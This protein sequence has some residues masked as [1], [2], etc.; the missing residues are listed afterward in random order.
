MTRIESKDEMVLSGSPVA[1]VG[2]A[3]PARRRRGLLNAIGAMV[4]AGLAR[5]YFKSVAW[6]SRK[7]FGT[8]EKLGFYLIPRTFYGPIPDTRTLPDE[9][10]KRHS[11]LIGIDMRPQAQLALMGELAERY[12]GEYGILPSQPTDDPRQYYYRNVLYGPADAELAYGLVRKH[13]PRRLIEVGSGNS[14][15]LLAQAVRRNNAET[16]CECRYTVIDPY[17]RPVV[18][19]GIPGVS[20]LIRKPIQHVPLDVFAQLGEGDI[21]F[22]DSSHVL[23]VGSDVAYQF[24]EV[25]PRLNAGVLVHFHDIFLPAEYHRDWVMKRRRFWNEQYILQTFLTYNDHFE[26]LWGSYYMKL[27]HLDA[28]RRAFPSV[29]P[30]EEP[31]SFWIR[32]TK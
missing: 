14:T 4:P 3:R 10:W 1:S 15:M 32:K 19:A 27:Y 13:A 20:E 17:A 12:G 28:L 24:L 16:G 9:L 29:R 21:L 11:Q 23:K 5:S 25:L 22:I 7:A 2:A 8:F 30:W 26:V 6:G 18:A 31:A